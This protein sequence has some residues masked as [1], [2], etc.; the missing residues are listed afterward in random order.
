MSTLSLTHAQQQ[1]T[2]HLSA[3]EDAARYAFRR[4]PPAGPRGGGRRG[5]RRR[6]ERLARPDPEGQGPPR[7]RRHRDR[8]QRDPLRPQRPAGRQHE[9]RPGCHG[10]L[11]Q[12]PEGPRL[13]GRQSRLQRPVHPRLA[14]RDVEGVAGR[15]PP[16]RPGRRRRLSGSTSRC[17]SA[18][19]PET[20]RQIA[21]L[22]AEGHEPGLVARIVGV[23][24]ARVSQLRTEL[25]ASWQAFQ[26]GATPVATV[27]V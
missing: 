11:P 10:R 12:G 21:E 6:L 19:L 1:F 25:E 16:G 2:A 9:L 15:G 8:Q 23:S 27:P 14:G 7:G 5:P 13:Q 22:L 20:K 26:G 18:G 24:P 17:G 4:M 3:V